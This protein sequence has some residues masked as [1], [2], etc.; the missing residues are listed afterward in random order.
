MRKTIRMALLACVLGVAAAGA[1]CSGNSAPDVKPQV[2]IE[3]DDGEKIVIELLPEYAPNTVAN[4][5]ALIQEGF[6]DGTVFHRIV[7]DFMIQGG[8]PLGNGTGN[9]G[10][11]IKGEFKN[12]GFKQN[13]LLHERGVL[14]M[15]RSSLPDSAGCQFFIVVAGQY[16]SLDGDYAAFGRVISGMDVVDKIVSGPRT[17]VRNDEAAQPRTMKTVTVDTFGETWPEPERIM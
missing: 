5:V 8:D 13:T 3:M 14:S 11:G 16:P 4:F 2:T 17:G 7:P 15:A 12:N 6:Y 1:G 10:Y 9:P